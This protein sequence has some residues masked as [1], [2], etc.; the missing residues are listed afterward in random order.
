MKKT[1]FAVLLVLGL[2]GCKSTVKK[3]FEC[4]GNDSFV[5]KNK[6][7]V[8]EG[9]PAI[10]AS[11]NCH[12]T[13]KDCTITGEGIHAAGNAQVTL[14]GGAITAASPNAAMDLSGNAKVFAQGTAVV[15]EVKKSGNAKAEGLAS[16]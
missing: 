14:E 8:V 1:A 11:G 16:K 13:C 12:L 7:F 4:T 6:V 5:L 3:T 10:D 15:G 2:I 9:G